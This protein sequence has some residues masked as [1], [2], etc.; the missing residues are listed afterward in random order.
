MC[1]NIISKAVDLSVL[2][3]ASE[4]NAMHYYTTMHLK[5]RIVIRQCTEIN[6]RFISILT[7]VNISTAIT[8]FFMQEHHK[9][10]AVLEYERANN[11]H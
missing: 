6:L 3:Q 2:L 11:E 10:Y 1:S 9:N 8:F 5:I 7:F 4:L